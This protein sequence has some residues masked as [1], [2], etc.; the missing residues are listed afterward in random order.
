M[1]NRLSDIEHRN[2]YLQNIIDQVIAHR[3]SIVYVKSSMIVFHVA[4][5]FELYSETT[6]IVLI[7]LTFLHL[8]CDK[9]VKYTSN[10]PTVCDMILLSAPARRPSYCWLKKSTLIFIY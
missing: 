8:K 4:V 5:L 10:L 1:H 7:A 2:V 3:V 6:K 9:F